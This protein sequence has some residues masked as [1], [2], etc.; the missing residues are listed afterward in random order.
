MSN[1]PFLSITLEGG[2]KTITFNNP[3]RKNAI[4]AEGT[5]E[6]VKALGQCTVDGTR[7]VVLTGAEGN[8]CSGADLGGNAMQDP[9]TY[10]VTT[11]LRTGINAAIL[12]IRNMDI[13]VIAKVRG[14]A[15]G[16]G[17]NFALA[18]DMIYATPEAMFSQIF[19]NI[20]LSSDG[21]GAF[22]MLKAMGYPK[23]FELMA[24]AAKI[25]AP[26]ALELGLINHLC[27]E[28]ELDATVQAMA[29][30]LASGP[31]VAIQQTKA[32]LREALNGTLESALEAEAR[33]QAKNFRSADF[34]EGVM[35]FLQ[36]RKPNFKG[37]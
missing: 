26:E 5:Q 30:R 22:F 6:L 16:V 9:K 8:F 24:T 2:V 21:G 14:V 3:S 28:A 20:G 23:A 37:E 12:N 18:C 13:P 31:F 25:S 15:A 10:D 32:N 36:K 4:S 11:Y 1:N 29:E 33:N 17:A 27:P 7:V 35:A 19:T 34:V